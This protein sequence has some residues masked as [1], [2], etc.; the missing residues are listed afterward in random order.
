[1]TL[2]PCNDRCSGLDE[3]CRSYIATFADG[4][5]VELDSREF[6]ERLS[7]EIAGSA[8]WAANDRHFLDYKQGC[9]FPIATRHLSNLN[10]NAGAIFATFLFTVIPH[11]Q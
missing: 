3:L 8:M 2:T 7:G 11:I 1:M 4:P 10:P 6:M 9:T 5:S